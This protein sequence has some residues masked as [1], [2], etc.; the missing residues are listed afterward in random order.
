MNKETGGQAFP[1][2]GRIGAE[3]GMTLRDYFAG[4]AMQG[5]I[6]NGDYKLFADCGYLAYVIADTMIEERKK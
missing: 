6:V 5:L 4:M 1:C 2:Q 3:K